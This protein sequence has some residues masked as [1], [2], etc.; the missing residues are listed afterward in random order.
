MKE[1]FI[2]F[3]LDRLPWSRFHLLIVI[4]PGITWILDGL[5]VTIVGSR[6]PALQSAETLHL[7]S[8]DVGA[9]AS[10]YVVGAVTGALGFGWITDR[11]GR[12]FVFYVTLIVYRM[13]DDHERRLAM[14]PA[15]RPKG[16]GSATAPG[17]LSS[18]SQWFIRVSLP[19]LSA[20]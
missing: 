19:M 11:F 16:S 15:H 1:G 5:E 8:S 4:G 20:V 6:G 7:S 10:F 12:R 2:P 13:R 3:R 18:I 17:R 14:L 9:V